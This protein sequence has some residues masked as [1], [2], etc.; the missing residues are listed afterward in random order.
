MIPGTKYFVGP[1]P[2]AH[3]TRI[4]NMDPVPDPKS[5]EE[6]KEEKPEAK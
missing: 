3:W 6:D 5:T 4:V 1:D 2:D